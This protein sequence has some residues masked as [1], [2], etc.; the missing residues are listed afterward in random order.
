[1]EGEYPMDAIRARL[2]YESH[3]PINRGTNM[4]HTSQPRPPMTDPFHPDLDDAT[5]LALGRATWATI[6]F[7]NLAERV[8]FAAA[9]DIKPGEIGR[10]L[11][12]A[13]LILA[14]ARGA[15]ADVA[16]WVPSAN[17]LWSRR[18]DVLHGSSTVDVDPDANTMGPPYLLRRRS[19][20]R[21]VPTAAVFDQLAADAQT[22]IEE[23]LR[24]D[25]SLAA[26]RPGDERSGDR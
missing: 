26:E 20:R 12:Q 16:E 10:V 24:L 4:T 25:I 13:E 6:R 18:N 5:L 19:G 7:G 14:N 17:A 8:C 3:R 23:A 15:R 21:A 2:T 22:L 11:R 1:M 9:P